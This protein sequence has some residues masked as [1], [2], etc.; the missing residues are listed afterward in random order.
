MGHGHTAT[1]QNGLFLNRRYHISITTKYTGFEKRILSRLEHIYLGFLPNKTSDVNMY[2]KTI[3]TKV[4]SLHDFDLVMKNVINL[5]SDFFQLFEFTEIPEE[6][7]KR[8]IDDF[9]AGNTA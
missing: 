9:Y 8:I 2:E 1:N 7:Y 4:E 3:E 6:I 5:L